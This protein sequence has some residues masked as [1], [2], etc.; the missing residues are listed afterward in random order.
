MDVKFVD[1]TGRDGTMT[2]KLPFFMAGRDGKENLS[3]RDGTVCFVSLEGTERCVE[4]F[5]TGRD[6]THFFLRRDVT[7]ILF[8]FDGMGGA[9]FFLDGRDTHVC[10][11]GFPVRWHG[12]ALSN[13]LTRTA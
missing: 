6:G 3:Q 8:Y 12:I 4:F 9:L 1:G 11:P 13:L 10:P 2:L 7:V 5:T